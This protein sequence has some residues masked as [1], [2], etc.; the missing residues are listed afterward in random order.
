MFDVPV[1]AVYPKKNKK[2]VK[3]KGSVEKEQNLNRNPGIAFM[4][5]Q[6]CHERPMKEPNIIKCLTLRQQTSN[7]MSMHAIN[8]KKAGLKMSIDYK[9]TAHN[10]KT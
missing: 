9:K 10:R 5:R 8:N 2:G 1:M 4:T 6:T 7:D 3:V